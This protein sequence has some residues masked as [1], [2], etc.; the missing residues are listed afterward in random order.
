MYVD[1][2][3]DLLE[4]MPSKGGS[5]VH[6]MMLQAFAED[7]PVM[8]FEQLGKVYRYMRRVRAGLD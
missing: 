8:D 3:P 5:R 6:T 2:K 4:G 7:L 1:S